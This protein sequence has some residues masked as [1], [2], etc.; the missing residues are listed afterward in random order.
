MT[1]EEYRSAIQKLGLSQVS[2]ARVLRINERTSRRY[3]R[4]ETSI[5]RRVREDLE[6]MME[7]AK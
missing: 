3:A 4:G 2:A 1:P 5:G 6:A 7:R